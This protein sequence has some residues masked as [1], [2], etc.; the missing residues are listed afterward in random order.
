MTADS[1]GSNTNSFIHNPNLFYGHPSI[2]VYAGESYITVQDVPTGTPITSTSYWV[3]LLSTAPGSDPE[4]PPTSDPSNDDVS[5]LTPPEENNDTDGDGISNDKEIEIGSDPNVSD[6]AV[7]NYAMNLGLVSGINAVRNDP[8]SY[9]LISVEDHEDE[10]SELNASAE[11]A[12]NEARADG[13]E[14]GKNTVIN[15]PS[16]FSLLTVE[17]NLLLTSIARAEGAQNVLNDPYSYNLLTREEFDETLLSLQLS[18][19]ANATP[20]TNGWFSFPVGVGYG[21]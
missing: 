21:Q 9:L 20:Y 13:I 18:K 16:A 12:I 17:Q 1:N 15:D 5:N 11:I 8:A 2:V 6:A 4:D 19:D 14:D 10:L 7:F 3:S